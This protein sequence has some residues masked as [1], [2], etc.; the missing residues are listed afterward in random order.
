MSISF[1]CST[2]ADLTPHEL[3]AMLRLRS[4]VFVV[5]QRCVYLDPDG[6]DSDALH[7]FGWT[8]DS[9][10]VLV[11]GVRILAPGVVYDEAAIGRVV[12][13]PAARG[14]GAGRAVMLRGLAECEI[15]FPGRGV[16]IGA[17][18]YLERFYESLGFRTVSE[19][20]DEDGIE[21]VTMLRAG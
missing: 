6:L 10:R 15:R 8:G 7:L 19:P 18:R 13:A 11:C 16:R 4:E 9:P 5:E 21:H 3:Y 14:L 1:V 12:S 20:Y 2:F 17:Q